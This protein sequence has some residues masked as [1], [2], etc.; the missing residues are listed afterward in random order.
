MESNLSTPP[1]NAAS[2]PPSVD[3]RSTVR[4]HAYNTFSTSAASSC[5]SRKLYYCNGF[6]VLP[7]ASIDNIGPNTTSKTKNLRIS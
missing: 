1:K 4:E 3:D 2:P 6:H 5:S 7:V